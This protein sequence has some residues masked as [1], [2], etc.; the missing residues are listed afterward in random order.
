MGCEK[1]EEGRGIREKRCRNEIW[2]GESPI[3]RPLRDIL[4]F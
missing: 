1:E 3:V 2:P 4:L